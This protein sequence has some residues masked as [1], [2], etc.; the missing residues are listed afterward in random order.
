MDADISPG[1]RFLPSAEFSLDA[2]FLPSAEFLLAARFL[3]SAEFLLYADIF[4]FIS[5]PTFFII[6]LYFY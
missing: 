5:A 2:R 3:P 4:V 6:F 1:A